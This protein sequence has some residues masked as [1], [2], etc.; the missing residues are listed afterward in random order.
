MEHEL[1][2]MVEDIKRALEAV[3]KTHS[4]GQSLKK[5]PSG[6]NIRKYRESLQKLVEE[7]GS[8]EYIF[9]HQA[10]ELY[11]DISDLLFEML[12]GEPAPYRKI[13][14][15]DTGERL[16]EEIKE[17]VEKAEE[18]AEKAISEVVEKIEEIKPP[19]E[20]E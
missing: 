7:L 1:E 6:E 14:P 3:E 16:T 15:P 18:E 20:K 11:E 8:L 9:T 19:A 12:E 13:T 2:K 4:H 17:L 5:E 10:E